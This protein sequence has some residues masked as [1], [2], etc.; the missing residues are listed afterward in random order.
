MS[1]TFAYRWNRDDLAFDY[2]SA[3]D[4]LRA[5][6]DAQFSPAR[7]LGGEIDSGTARVISAPHRTIGGDSRR[8][9]TVHCQT[10]RSTWHV[11]ISKK[12]NYSGCDH[13][14]ATAGKKPGH[15]LDDYHAPLIPNLAAL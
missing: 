11:Y 14:P 3:R 12:G 2:Q 15:A 4:L 1:L 13:E 10:M 5:A 8:H 9:M 6:M 7:A